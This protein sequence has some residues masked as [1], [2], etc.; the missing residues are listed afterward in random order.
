MDSEAQGNKLKILR[1]IYQLINS[2][3]VYVAR[4]PTD[5][6]ASFYHHYRHLVGYEGTKKD[7]AE[8]FLNEQVIYSPFNEH[9]MDFWNLRDE[10]N[11]LFI[12]YEE[13]KDNIEFVIRKCISFLNKSYTQEQIHRLGKHLSVDSMRANPS[14]NNDMLVKTAKLLNNN[15]FEPFRYDLSHNN[16][17]NAFIYL[18]YV[19]F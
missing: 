17:K 6:A 4:N 15:N 5:V 14:C 8:A 16:L 10:K 13:M 3:I 7:F 12:T 18:L 2:Q 9:V 11:I 1:I 19:S